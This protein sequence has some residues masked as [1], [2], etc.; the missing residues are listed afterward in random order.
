MS[1]FTANCRYNVRSGPTGQTYDQLKQLTKVDSWCKVTG[2]VIAY[3]NGNVNSVSVAGKE[4]TV[5][6]CISEIEEMIECPG[7][8]PSTLLSDD[9]TDNH[10]NISMTPER[11]RRMVISTINTPSTTSE[12]SRRSVTSTGSTPPT[13]YLKSF[14]GSK[15]PGPMTYPLN[16]YFVYQDWK[17][18]ANPFSSLFYADR[19]IPEYSAYKLTHANLR[20]ITKGPLVPRRVVRKTWYFDK[21]RS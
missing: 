3:L 6:D 9:L 18:A 20:R 2:S 17:R 15:P 19:G 12:R 5:D 7:D 14:F 21:S 11:F 1:F 10:H 16:S 13:K 8:L 4:L